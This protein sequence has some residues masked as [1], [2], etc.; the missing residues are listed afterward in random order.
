VDINRRPDG[1]PQDGCSA[2]LQGRKEWWPSGRGARFGHIIPHF[3]I[4]DALKSRNDFFQSL[5]T[6][7]MQLLDI[8]ER[9]GFCV[10]AR[11]VSEFSIVIGLIAHLISRRIGWY[12]Q[13]SELYP[14]IGFTNRLRDPAFSLESKF[15]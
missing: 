11:S 5:S 4:R 6:S 14:S 3:C 7:K 10:S 9:R 12:G 8:S 1:E 13:A 15:V 2:R